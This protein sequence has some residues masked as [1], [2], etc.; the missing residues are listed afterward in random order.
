MFAF[1]RLVALC[2][3]APPHTIQCWL[4]FLGCCMYQ[5]ASRRKK[6]EDRTGMQKNEKGFYFKRNRD[7]A[8]YNLTSRRE[9][10]QEIADPVRTGDL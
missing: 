5:A 10:V 4:T 8:G 1:T 9:V 2:E 6:L 3:T 7:M